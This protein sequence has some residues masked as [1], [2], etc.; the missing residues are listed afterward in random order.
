MQE[1]ARLYGVQTAYHDIAGAERTASPDGLLA[2]L[3]ALGVPLD[4]WAGAGDA[5]AAR[6]QLLAAR[7]LEPVIAL[8]QG[9]DFGTII[10]VPAGEL[11]RQLR[12]KLVLDDGTAREW[13]AVPGALPDAGADRYGLDGYLP[14]W[15]PFPSDLPPG[16]HSLYAE[17][18]GSFSESLV[19]VAPPRAVQPGELGLGRSW[20]GFLP[21]HA[22]RRAKD[23]GAGDYSGLGELAAWLGGQGASFLA[24]LP[25]LPSFL[26]K[27]YDPS[28]YSPVSR[29]FWNELYVDISRVPELE[30]CD[31][32]RRQIASMDEMLI[33]G[34]L[35]DDPHVRY[36]EVFAIKRMLLSKLA[37]YFFENPGQRW[38]AFAEFTKRRPEVE[39]YARFRA[40]TEHRRASWWN[41]P[42]EQKAGR[43][44]EADFKFEARDFYV[45]A[46][47]IA[48]EQMKD[49]THRAE[50]SGAGL[51]LDLP[52]GVHPDGYDVWRE[53]G[54]YANGAATG[55]PPDPFFMAGQNWGFAPLQPEQ[56]REQRY[57][58][59]AH[60]IRHHLSAAKLLR[61]DH[62]MSLHRL[63]WIP[64]GAPATEGVYVHYRAEELFAV[65]ALESLRNRSALIGEDLGT[66]PDAV[67]DLMSKRGFGRLYVMQFMCTENPDA[68]I[69]PVPEGAAACLN[70]HD[71]PPFAS[72][73]TGEEF[74]RREK[75]GFLTGDQVAAEKAARERMRAAVVSF[76]RRE[77]LLAPDRDD[78]PAV[79]EACSAWIGKSPAELA[80]VSLEDLWQET[81]PQNMPGTVTEN[82]NWSRK[83]ARSLEHVEADEAVAA[84]FARWRSLRP[85]G[86]GEA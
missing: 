56:L 80:V 65:C 5:L 24:T 57:A 72:F 76:L 4:C 14:R 6:R 22:L 64:R 70:T 71:M 26:A 29:I 18:A 41:W 67:R 73:W 17:L 13:T 42:A 53:Q 33:F 25:L 3:R 2:I 44:S 12:F 83:A 20:G 7:F 39:D 61:I 9:G 31:E 69:Q 36:K 46:Q 21:L 16:Y 68:A 79:M 28:P 49:A 82:A 15:L 54:C 66:V 38:K 52:V 85:K 19:I 50:V 47:W 51:Y 77:G 11:D 37:R 34:S 58:H 45:Y 75:L 1:L 74:D 48:H 78:L 59:F 55:A 30:S 32:V 43:L 60:V 8:W 84:M 81:E 62:V 40:A 10:R 63:Y 27:P 35:R 86:G 23:F